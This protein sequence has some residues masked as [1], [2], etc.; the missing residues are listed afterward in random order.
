MKHG[1]ELNGV[2]NITMLLIKVEED[3]G[4]DCLAGDEGEKAIESIK[5]Q[6]ILTERYMI[7]YAEAMN[8]GTTP[9]YW[10]EVL[11]NPNL[12]LTNK[13]RVEKITKF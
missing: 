6:L 3:F 11:Q 7:A 9:P 8:A 10:H 12:Y 2:S 13:E 5:E 1:I 4:H